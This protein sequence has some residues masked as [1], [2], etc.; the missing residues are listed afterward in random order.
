MNGNRVI[1]VAGNVVTEGACFN[2]CDLCAGCADPLFAE[3]NPFNGSNQSD[4]LT[5]VAAGCVYEQAEN[6]DAAAPSDDGS[7]IFS[8]ASDCPGDLND[9][10]QVGTPDLLTFLSNFGTSCD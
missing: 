5:A 4:C 10:G 2:S 1:T 7:C 8:G 6:Y 9:D 3:Y